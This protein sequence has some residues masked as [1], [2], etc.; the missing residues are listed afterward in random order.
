MVMGAVLVPT[1]GLGL[2]SMA[3]EGLVSWFDSS[4]QSSSLV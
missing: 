3:M 1:L 2:L 4:S